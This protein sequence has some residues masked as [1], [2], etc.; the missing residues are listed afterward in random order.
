VIR[1]PDAA[2]GRND[3]RLVETARQFGGAASNTLAT[4]S[5]GVARVRAAYNA[6]VSAF[7]AVISGFAALSAGAFG[8]NVPMAMLAGCF[9][10]LLGW[11]ALWNFRKAFGSAQSSRPEPGWNPDRTALGGLRAAGPAAGWALHDGETL[12]S[13]D[14]TTI[15]YD[16]TKIFFRAV[17]SFLACAA[18]AAVLTRVAYK[19]PVFS[20]IAL[21]ALG[22]GLWRIFGLLFKGTDKDLTA[23]SWNN[24]Q[25]R[26][27]TLTS[28]CQVTWAEFESVVVKRNTVRL[29]R[30]IP[31]ATS[32]TLMFR[33]RQ[34][35]SSRKLNV[36]AS[37]LAVRP[38]DATDLMRRIELARAQ[39]A[40]NPMR[41]GDQRNA[42]RA[43]TRDESFRG[44]REGGTESV[45]NPGN[46]PQGLQTYDPITIAPAAF[47]RKV[48]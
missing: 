47:G 3:D 25:I 12:S 22:F 1:K 2:W 23:I 16:R 21:G 32:Y 30:L 17:T 13:G 33:L 35:G 44:T 41:A 10:L 6:A 39:S 15:C 48:P 36:P 26:V 9:S 27:R 20:L 11:L 43:H 18:M 34:N 31:I 24:C 14:S 4:A 5:S 38:R 8:R 40:R 37:V 19:A 42:D 45:A 46:R 28:S 7:M 29:L